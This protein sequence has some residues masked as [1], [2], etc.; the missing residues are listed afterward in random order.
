MFECDTSMRDFMG[1][2]MGDVG[3]GGDGGSHDTEPTMEVNYGKNVRD[4]VR[5]LPW[6]ERG[7]G[8]N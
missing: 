7:T 8:G 4:E 5:M 6:A 3:V 2:T 1:F